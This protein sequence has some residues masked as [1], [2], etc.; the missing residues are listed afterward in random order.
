MY[1]LLKKINRCTYY[2]INSY[3]DSK[4][5]PIKS[6]Y[7]SIIKSTYKGTLSNRQKFLKCFKYKNMANSPKLHHRELQDGSNRHVYGY[8]INSNLHKVKLLKF[9]FLIIS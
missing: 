4:K 8:I 2:K 3:S 5:C 1:F 9:K 7:K 6:I